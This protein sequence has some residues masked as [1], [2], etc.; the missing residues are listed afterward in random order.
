[1]I[2]YVMGLFSFGEKREKEISYK[3]TYIRKKIINVVEFKIHEFRNRII[4]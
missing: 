1:M 2:V 3:S 4:K